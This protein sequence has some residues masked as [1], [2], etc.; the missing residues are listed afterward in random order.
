[1]TDINEC[2]SN[3][4][5]NGATCADAVN[6]YTC[7]CVAGFTGILCETSKQSLK[8]SSRFLRRHAWNFLHQIITKFCRY[9]LIVF[10]SKFFPCKAHTYDSKILRNAAME[11]SI[12]LSLFT[13][14]TC[15]HHNTSGSVQSLNANSLRCVNYP[16]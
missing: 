7:Y 4:C 13:H 2:A 6:M 8:N 14:G 3:P 5:Q 9:T 11:V 10:R 1:M 12:R 15:K 16:V